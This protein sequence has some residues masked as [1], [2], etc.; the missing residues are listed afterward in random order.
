MLNQTTIEFKEKSESMS[1]DKYNLGFYNNF[2]QVF[3]SN[4]LFWFFPIVDDVE[5]GGY[6][7]D[8]KENIYNRMKNK[9]FSNNN[10]LSREKDDLFESKKDLNN[11]HYYVWI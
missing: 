6:K 8:I 11:N 9:D 1:N 10:S 3:G 2:R 4:I 7:F 5:M